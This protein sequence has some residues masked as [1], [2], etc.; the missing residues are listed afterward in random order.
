M[1][2]CRFNSPRSNHTV[3]DP[4][5]DDLIARAKPFG[6][7]L[8]S[9]LLRP[10]ELGRWNPIP[11]TDPLDDF[12]RVWLTFGAKLSLPIELI[13]DL[14]IGQVAR[15]FSNSIDHCERVAYAVRYVGREL[16]TDVATRAALPA[17]MH[18][19]LF[20]LGWFLTGD[21][22]DQLAQHPLSLIGLTG[23]C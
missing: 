4:I 7:L 10:L 11:A 16:Y 23:V 17:D 19:D 8:D 18:Q 20:S 5:V 12:H 13:G 6:K 1:R 14:G 3:L 9:Q 2:H 15:Q 22:R 21:V